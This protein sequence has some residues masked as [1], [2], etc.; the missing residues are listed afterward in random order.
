MV[1]MIEVMERRKEASHTR[2]SIF[3]DVT[4]LLSM[5]GSGDAL[6]VC[7]SLSVLT[8]SGTSQGVGWWWWWWGGGGGGGGRGER[9][10]CPR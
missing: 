2:L 8:L 5:T 9:G 1:M 4:C 7:L 6:L 3:K 10:K